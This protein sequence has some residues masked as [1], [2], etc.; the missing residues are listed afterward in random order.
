MTRDVQA[1]TT[2]SLTA[3]LRTA[4]APQTRARARAVAGTIR[5]DGAAVAARLLVDAVSRERPPVSA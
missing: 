3:A 1:L 4:L 5:T 2:E